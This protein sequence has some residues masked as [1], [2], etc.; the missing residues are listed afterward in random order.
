MIGNRDDPRLRGTDAHAFRAMDR[1]WSDWGGDCREPRLVGDRRDTH[2]VCPSP[3]HGDPRKRSAA[4]QQTRLA[5]VATDNALF[6]GKA[7]IFTP[8]APP[9]AVAQTGPLAGAQASFRSN[10][11]GQASRAEGSLEARAHC[12]AQGVS[13]RA[14]TRGGREG[15]AIARPRANTP[16]APATTAAASPDA[17]PRPEAAPG[18]Q[19]KSP[20][21]APAQNGVGRKTCR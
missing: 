19:R 16:T 18:P 4:G 17:C 13:A 5:P 6:A 3:Q 12:S 14:Q 20:P 8:S 1:G 21:N 11:F 7:P 15:E 9:N 10:P 2:L